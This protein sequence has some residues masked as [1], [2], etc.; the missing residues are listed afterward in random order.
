VTFV[1]PG[2]NYLSSGDVLQPTVL[3]V[4]CALFAFGDITWILLLRRAKT[5]P[6]RLHH[7]MTIL[8][9][10]KV[11]ALLCDAMAYNSLA[12]YG[13]TTGWNTAF[14]VTNFISSFLLLDV[15]GAPR[16]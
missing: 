5:R 1:N 16:W 9:T 15:V 2:P 12:H 6:R 7:F 4:M 14:Y 8:C 10:A 3:G 13:R 11:A